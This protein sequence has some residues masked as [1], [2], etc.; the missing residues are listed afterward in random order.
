MSVQ[1]REHCG[2]PWFGD[3]PAQ[4]KD[5]V[6]AFDSAGDADSPATVL[7]TAREH[8]ALTLWH[9]LRRTAGAQ[10]AQ[11]FERFAGLVK[12]PA[13]MTRD[14]VLRGDAEA[15]DAS[16]NALGLGSTEWWRDWKRKWQELTGRGK[17]KSHQTPEPPCRCRVAARTGALGHN[18]NQVRTGA[19]VVQRSPRLRQ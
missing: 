19:A 9:L 4:L 10:R 1:Y 2:T 5:A 14:A 3:A 13:I 16:W 18:R 8:D 7:R 15:V 6:A 11:V 12:L 17:W